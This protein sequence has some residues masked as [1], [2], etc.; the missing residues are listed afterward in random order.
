MNLNAFVFSNNPKFRITR[1]VLFWSIWILYDTFFVALSWSK[2]PFSKSFFPSLLVEIFS[3][4]IDIL[5]CYLII[6]FFIPRF[7]SRGKYLTMIFLWLA[8]S[9]V[10]VFLFR[11]YTTHINPLIYTVYGMPYRM[12][13]VSFI[14]DFFDLFGQINMEGCMAAAIKLGKMWYIK[15]LE[16][17]LIKKER[18]K[19]ELTSEE[20]ITKPV[21]LINA[22]TKVETLS[23][24]T[25]ELIP[26]IIEQIKKLMLYVMYDNNQPKVA[27]EKEL[28]LLKEYIQIE[29][30]GLKE[31][32][33]INLKLPEQTNG[34]KIAPFIILPLVENSFHQLSVL[35]VADKFIDIEASVSSGNFIMDIA[36]S[37]P[38]DTSTLAN[39][40]SSFINAINK[41]LDLLYPHSHKL[42]V[43]IRPD[44]FMINLRIDLNEAI[45]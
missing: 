27:L 40:S 12:H 11:M 34:N 1:H 15:H 5:F 30:T 28:E 38:V 45:N 35:D 2:Y 37:K 29:R 20:G 19:V 17:D 26:E 32:I 23:K 8:S 25:P 4:P 36:W 39:G 18:K 24:E 42:K 14:W 9:F 6:Y 22:L 7:L 3:F 31:N 43:V 13:S 10:Y 41:R 16:L 33:Q 21:F 44:V